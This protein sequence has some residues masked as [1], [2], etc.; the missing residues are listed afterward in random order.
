MFTL[1]NGGTVQTGGAVLGQNPGSD[2]TVVITGPG[3]TAIDTGTAVIG[4]GGS[5]TVEITNGGLAVADGGTTIGPNGLLTGNGTNG[6]LGRS[7]YDSNGVSGGFRI[8][9]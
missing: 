5:G 4:Q 3:S 1:S 8:S 6:Q 9:F 7:N 2:G